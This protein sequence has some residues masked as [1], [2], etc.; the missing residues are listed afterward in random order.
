MKIL[1]TIK[2]NWVKITGGAVAVLLGA[3]ISS[4][5][6]ELPSSEK[7]DVS[8]LTRPT[9]KL[10]LTMSSN[11]QDV[12]KTVNLTHSSHVSHASHSSHYSHV[13]HRSG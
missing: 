8:E 6:A 11:N 1:K 4:N 3:A 10:V 13:S 9:K 12:M 7:T 2:R 5:A